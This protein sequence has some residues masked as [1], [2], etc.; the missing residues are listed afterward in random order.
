MRGIWL[1]A[2]LFGLGCG[3]GGG[4]GPSVPSEPASLDHVRLGLSVPEEGVTYAC[5]RALTMRGEEGGRAQAGVELR[6]RRQAADGSRLL[7]YTTYRELDVAEGGSSQ[8]DVLGGRLAGLQLRAL[9]DPHNHLVEGPEPTGARAAPMLGPSAVLLERLLTPYYPDHPVRPGES[10]SEPP[11][12]VPWSLHTVLR[13]DVEVRRTFTL[14]T[15]ERI[16]DRRVAWIDW[17]VTATAQ[18]VEIAGVTLSA[19]AVLRG[20]SSV[21]LA[22][23]LRGASSFDVSV[24]IGRD[25]MPDVLGERELA[26]KLR[27]T[28]EPSTDGR[29]ALIQGVRP[30]DPRTEPTDVPSGRR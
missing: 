2:L 6:L 14:R 26:A 3:G 19:E 1:G 25:G 4:P 18:G 16:G 27:E 20:V 21:D 11:F 8:A 13:T 9:V 28:C 30:V 12:V 24:S 17:D 23:G 10:W 29:G 7:R 5:T 15:V 22:D